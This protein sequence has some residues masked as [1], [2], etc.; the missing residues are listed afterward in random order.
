MLT[1]DRCHEDR[2][3][4]QSCPERCF[5][6]EQPMEAKEPT[7]FDRI[8]YGFSYWVSQTLL[9]GMERVVKVIGGVK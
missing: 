1:Q 3:Y 8:A 9:P 6:N 2:A 4:C 5:P 7:A